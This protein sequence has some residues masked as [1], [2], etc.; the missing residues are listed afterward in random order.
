MIPLQAEILD[1]LPQGVCIID[2]EFSVLLWN[3]VLESWTGIARDEIFGKDLRDHYPNVDRKPFS[4]RLRSVLEGG[5]PAI[6]SAQLH[7]PFL[8]CTLLNGDPRIQQTTVTACDDRH[9]VIVIE[10][11]SDLTRLIQRTRATNVVLRETQQEAESASV[12][13]SAFLAN[14]SHEIRTPMTAILG[15]SESLLEGGLADNE[16]RAALETIRANGSFLLELINDILDLSKV[17]SGRLELEQ[18]EFAPIDLLSDIARSIQPRCDEHD[19]SIQLEVR[20]GVPE[21]ASND[22]T[23]IRQVLVNLLSNAIKFSHRGATVTAAVQFEPTEKGGNLAYTIEDNGVGMTPDQVDRVFLPFVQ[24][25]SSTTRKYGGTGLGLSISQRLADLLGGSLSVTSELGK[26][27]TFALTIPTVVEQ[28]THLVDVIKQGPPES[29]PSVAAQ[30]AVKLSCRVLVAE[31]FEANQRLIRS[32]L[33]R[34]GATVEI[35]ENGIIAVEAVTRAIR[36]GTPFDV[37]VMDVQMP[38]MDGQTATRTL[39]RLGCET[40]IIALTANAMDADR[41]RCKLAGC[42]RF[43]TKPI[44]RAALLQTIYELSAPTPSRAAPV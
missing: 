14:M 12:A 9:A 7:K 25:D 27:S 36:S 23:R 33:K 30:Q 3:R 1:R 44:D 32:I 37:I 10:D 20:S 11:V 4:S 13:K 26:G 16:A 5:P 21:C 29:E 17:E 6:F 43:L 39:R 34:A 41:E 40:P 42:D 38:E 22:P 19:V 31:D 18:V 2:E 24:A 28:G 15:F 8:P 35:A